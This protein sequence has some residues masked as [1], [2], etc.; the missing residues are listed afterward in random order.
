MKMVLQAGYHD[1]DLRQ[2]NECRMF[3]QV[4]TLADISDACGTHISL[5]AWEGKR[6]TRTGFYYDWPHPSPSLSKVHWNLWRKALSTGLLR[7]TRVLAHPLGIWLKPAP[8]RWQWHFSPS[9]NRIYAK[10]GFLWRL[11]PRSLARTS[12]RRGGIRYLRS[13]EFVY[14]PPTDLRLASVVQHGSHFLCTGTSLLFG[15]EHPCAPLSHCPTLS[16][17]YA[18]SREL[19]PAADQWVISQLS[20]AD[21]GAFLVVSLRKGTAIAVS[22]GSFKDACGTAAFMIEDCDTPSAVSQAIG[23]NTVPGF[24]EDHSTYRSELS[25][26]SGII[27]TVD[28]ICSAHGVL[29]GAIEVGLDGDQAMKACSGLWP[30]KADQVDFD[31][32]QDIRAK[33]KHSPLVWHWRWI[34][35]H[36]DDKTPFEALDRWAQLNVICDGLA[37]AFWNNCVSSHSWLPNHAFGDENWSVWIDGKKLS[38]LDKTK[39]YAYTF[40]ARTKRYWH[41]KHSLNPELIKA[42]N[43]DA[44]PEAMF[45]VT[46]GKRRWLLKHAT[47]FCGVGKM[48][49]QRENQDH[50]DCPQCGLSE[51]TVHILICQDMGAALSFIMALQKLD[52]RIQAL[53]TAPETCTAMQ[54]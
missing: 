9:E 53:T 19:L 39:L 28:C 20:L 27:A 13:E 36:Q 51:D 31:L 5:L 29:S 7:S 33:I 46:F 42:I 12:P 45:K 3:L 18:R 43:W 41:R 17:D 16:H 6:D 44:C 25:A 37:K 8:S 50:D 4:T 54:E 10:K 15:N 11:Y 32:L 47:G 52:T 26:V 24:T 21:K 1:S 35:G 48:E 49:L 23:V 40:S 22:D 30:L 38:R 34:E 2:L 14:I